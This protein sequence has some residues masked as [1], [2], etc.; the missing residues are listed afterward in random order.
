MTGVSTLV[1]LRF[2]GK[3]RGL[4]VAYPLVCHGL[5]TAAAV[6]VL[7]RDFV[8]AGLRVKLGAAL[9]LT[10]SETCAVLEFW[11]ALHDLGK[12]VPCFQ[13]QVG[14]PSG[15][16]D[17][18]KMVAHERASALCVPHGLEV[19]GYPAPENGRQWS[20]LVGQVL[21]GHHGLFESVRRME[22]R[23]QHFESEGLGSAEWQAQRAE[24]MAA[25]AEVIAA[26]VPVTSGDRTAAVLVAG[27]VILGDWLASQT[28]YIRTRLGRVPVHGGVGELKKFFDGSV[29]EIEA[30]VAEA[31]L[32]RLRLRSGSFEQEFP[33]P[34]NELQ[35]SL[36]EKLPKI[37]T[38]PGLLLAAA[39]MGFGKTEAALHAARLMSEA[40]GAEGLFVALPTMATSDEMFK[41]VAGYLARRG[42]GSSSASLAHGMAWLRPVEEMLVAAVAAEGI[43]SDADNQVRCAEW[44]RG[45]K[46]PLLAGAGVGTID[47]L[48]LSVLPV[49][50]N[51]LRL[52]ALAGR[53]VVIDEVHAFDS[54]MRGLLVRL[55][56]WLGE[57]GV[58]VVL[59][60]ATLPG[61]IARDLAAAYLGV[62][63]GMEIAVPYPGWV[64][65]ERGGQPV[66][67]AVSF[68]EGQVRT[69]DVR[70]AEVVIDKDGAADRVPVLKRELA[71]LA[72]QGGC[73][74]VVCTTVPEAQQ[75]FTALQ[76][77]ADERDI[78][79]RLLHARFP[80]HQRQAITSEVLKALG[81]PD[82]DDEQEL[83]RRRNRRFVLVSTALIEQSL[84]IDA[85]LVVSDL[86]PIELILQRAGRL[87]RHRVCDA[88]RPAWAMPE[89]GGRRRMVVLSVPRDEPRRILALRRWTAI[90]PAANLVR[91]HRLLVQRQEPG[92]EIPGDVQWLVDR[93]NPG[94]LPVV[95]DCLLEGFTEEELARAAEDMV[96]RQTAEVASIPAPPLSNLAKLSERAVDEQQART[97]FNAD[98]EQVLPLFETPDGVVRLGSPDGSPLPDMDGRGMTREH[99][100]E[101][102]KHIVPVHGSLVR[103]HNERHRLPEPW[104]GIWPLNQLIA[105]RQRVDASGTVHP[106]QI[107]DRSL[108]LDPTLGLRRVD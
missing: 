21:G 93:G 25:L 91:A 42:D 67:V 45:S 20:F 68:P 101:V 53:T 7:W 73:A 11:A 12:I 78:E 99:T 48:L 82:Q 32:S 97:R 90:Y 105:L 44:M 13:R 49:L 55:L 107:G 62:R 84:D 83:R 76:G 35:R 10:E 77:W 36:A 17:D 47:Q 79:L 58:P 59:M 85:D 88:L 70:L 89:P 66:P 72:E 29:R 100:R 43:S 15:Y 30:W 50:H 104:G 9:G 71:P 41:R 69:L 103:G 27:L 75:T 16:R 52:F 40:A 108:V 38:G 34:P 8:S 19:L 86:A 24:V 1:D 54:Y 94:E 31:G 22:L 56:R 39:P 18:R 106:A 14:I 33:F 80:V 65:A 64:Y 87:Q 46:R 5:D 51:S 4:G 63:S 92:V 3:E 81:K 26:P 61:H 23:P 6:R 98:S 96:Q 37:V 74:V 28:G 102:M 60:S 57:C 95:D 2:W